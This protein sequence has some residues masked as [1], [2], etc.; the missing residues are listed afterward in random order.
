MPKRLGCLAFLFSPASSSTGSSALAKLNSAPQLYFTLRQTWNTLFVFH[1][2]TFVIVLTVKF[3]SHQVVRHISCGLTFTPI[4]T[5]HRLSWVVIHT[6]ENAT[7]S[8]CR[9]I[10]IVSARLRRSYIL[11]SHVNDSCQTQ[12]REKSMPSL[13]STQAKMRWRI[14]MWHVYYLRL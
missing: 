5:S 14:S 1:Q 6:T 10:L 2:S 9:L 7:A 12:T 3:P 4:C 8:G 13:S 11:V